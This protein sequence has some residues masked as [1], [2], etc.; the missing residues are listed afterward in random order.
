MVHES[1][2]VVSI[3][4]EIRLQNFIH[5]F[6]YFEVSVMFV[7]LGNLALKVL[8]IVDLYMLAPLDQTKPA[9]LVIAVS[10][11]HAVAALVLLNKKVAV[12]TLLGVETHP[13]DVF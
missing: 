10:T 7:F 13:I 3:P 5:F 2:V 12:R 11:R 1:F 6:S 4:L 8:T 9:E